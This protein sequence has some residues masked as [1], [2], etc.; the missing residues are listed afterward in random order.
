MVLRTDSMNKKQV[1]NS[2]VE[3]EYY[4]ALDSEG[5]GYLAKRK[6]VKEPEP[7]LE[8]VEPIKEEPIKEE[9]IYNIKRR[10]K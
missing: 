4:T 7:K 8:I 9:P 6:I 10:K 1:D 2:N 3:F 5:K